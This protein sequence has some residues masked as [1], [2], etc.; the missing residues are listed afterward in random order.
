VK[1]Y[2]D[3]GVATHISPEPC[4]AIREGRSEA[5]VGIT[6][7]LAIVPRNAELV[8]DADGEA[9]PEGNTSWCEIASA[10]MVLRG[11]R[12]WRARKPLDR[13]L[14]EVTTDQQSWPASGRRMRR[15]R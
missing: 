2:R 1:V 11:L 12:H 15:S 9:G 8:Q 5:S 14:G 10:K 13:E 7:K 6:C 3:E 4:A